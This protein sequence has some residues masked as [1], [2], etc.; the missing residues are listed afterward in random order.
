MVAPLPALRICEVKH[1]KNLLPR[2]RR[3]ERQKLVD[4]FAAL[5]KIDQAPQRYARAPKAGSTAHALGACPDRLIQ[6]VSLLSGHN[7]QVKVFRR[8]GAIIASTTPAAS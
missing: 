4:A 2:D 6:A 5:K 8:E 3:I 1:G 7:I